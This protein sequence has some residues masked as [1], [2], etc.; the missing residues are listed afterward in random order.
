MI[1]KQAV[2][3]EII[4]DLKGVSLWYLTMYFYISGV[5]TKA[6]QSSY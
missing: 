1:S 6:D 2:L 5:G 4:E 3:D